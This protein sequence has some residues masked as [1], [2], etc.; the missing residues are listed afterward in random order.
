MNSHILAHQANC[1]LEAI[2]KKLAWCE[3]IT[4]AEI[5][6]KPLKIIQKALSFMKSKANLKNQLM[7]FEETYV[8]NNLIELS[9]VELIEQEG[10]D[11]INN[12]INSL[13]NLI[14]EISNPNFDI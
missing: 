13:K 9:M 14:Q 11:Y 12:M 1:E 4:Q 3:Q 7:T 8:L 5:E 2:L 6:I 10:I